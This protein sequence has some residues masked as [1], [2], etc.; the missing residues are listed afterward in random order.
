MMPRS[1]DR[2]CVSCAG[3]GTVRVHDIN[4]KDLQSCIHVITLQALFR[5]NYLYVDIQLPSRARQIVSCC[6]L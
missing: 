1:G 6:Q 4:A 5:I 2:L 3:D